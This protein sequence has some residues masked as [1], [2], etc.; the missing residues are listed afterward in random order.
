MTVRAYNLAA[1]LLLDSLSTFTSYELCSYSKL[2]VYAL[3]AGTVSL[4][5]VDFKSKVVDSAE[6]KAVVGHDGGSHSRSDRRD[7]LWSRSRGRGNARRNIRI[8]YSTQNRHCQIHHDTQA[9]EDQHHGRLATAY[10]RKKS[11]S[12]I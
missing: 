1:P 8:R 9:R 4:K 3:L 10:T 2:I 6:I 5:R 12:R 11:I 7:V